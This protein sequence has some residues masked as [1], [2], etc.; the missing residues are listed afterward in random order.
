M[1]LDRPEEGRSK[2]KL[3]TID[4]RRS[5]CSPSQP[6][7]SSNPTSPCAQEHPG[8]AT[9]DFSQEMRRFVVVQRTG[10]ALEDGM[11][12]CFLCRANLG[13]EGW[14]AASQR[15]S[16]SLWLRW[17]RTSDPYAKL[18]AQGK[19]CPE[20]E[21][22]REIARWK[23]VWR[24]DAW[25]PER[26]WSKLDTVPGSRGRSPPGGSVPSERGK[27]SRGQSRAKPCPLHHGGFELQ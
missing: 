7:K 9:R 13:T 4:G 5:P 17:N 20:E 24:V 26:M 6:G 10:A 16:G 2:E 22:R 12:S 14:D 11:K 25:K 19:T 23:D 8:G 27:Q 3:H 15:S 18:P 21:S 1:G